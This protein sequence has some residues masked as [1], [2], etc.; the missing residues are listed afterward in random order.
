MS[1]LEY[2]HTCDLGSEPA[3]KEMAK[4]TNKK[5]ANKKKKHIQTKLP[6]F[7]THFFWEYL[8]H[9][10]SFYLTLSSS[11]LQSWNAKHGYNRIV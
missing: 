6:Q 8:H 3:L 5:R 7:L 4:Q 11:S 9:L 1:Y 2:I 10:P